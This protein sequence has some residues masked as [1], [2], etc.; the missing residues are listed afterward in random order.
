LTL[1]AGT[2]GV[3]L[4][5]GAGFDPV[6]AGLP[7]LRFSAAGGLGCNAGALARSASLASGCSLA[8]AAAMLSC[9][10]QFALLHVLNSAKNFGSG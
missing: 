9:A 8:A 3:A 2:D 5:G 7:R 4:S 1:I 6:I 10:I